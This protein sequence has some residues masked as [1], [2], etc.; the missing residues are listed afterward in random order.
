M[1]AWDGALA[2]A[3]AVQVTVQVAAVNDGPVVTAGGALAY[4]ENGLGAVVDATVV[5]SDVDDLQLTGAVVMIDSVVEQ[6]GRPT[7]TVVD[8]RGAPR[9]RG[10][11]EPLDPIAGHIPGALNR[12]FT[13]NFTAEGLFKS[14][15]VLRAEWDRV[16]SGRSAS[17][18]VHHCGSG[19][20]A[21]PNI[22][23]MEI[24]GLNGSALFAGSWSEWVADPQ[25]P[26]AKG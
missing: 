9:Y 11:V 5:I 18:V 4:V 10:E 23:A 20:S 7:Q 8:A 13:D 1:K 15:D 25:R 22:L 2:S 6:L 3:T 17:S 14:P 16:L 24:A 12:P 21:V 19:V 26:V